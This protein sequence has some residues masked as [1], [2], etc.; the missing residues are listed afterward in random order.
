MG[1]WADEWLSGAGWKFDVVVVLP[2]LLAL[3]AV[4]IYTG[5]RQR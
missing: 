4:Y 2:L 5:R 1:A 3:A